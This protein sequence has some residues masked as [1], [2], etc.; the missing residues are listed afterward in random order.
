[1]VAWHVLSII[2]VVMVECGL[3]LYFG[4]ITAAYEFVGTIH[5]IQASSALDLEMYEC[6]TEHLLQS[7][8]TLRKVLLAVFNTR[9][10]CWLPSPTD[11]LLHR[12]QGSRFSQ[13]TAFLHEFK[14]ASAGTGEQYS[15]LYW[16]GRVKNIC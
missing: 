13:S 3:E 7:A 8:S 14:L 16:L 11:I 6:M 9:I 5:S 2:I 4:T 15:T 12:W 10:P 1:M